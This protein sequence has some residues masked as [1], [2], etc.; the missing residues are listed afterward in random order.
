MTSTTRKA[1]IETG[2]WAW[3]GEIRRQARGLSNMEGA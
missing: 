3:N 1:D 2:A